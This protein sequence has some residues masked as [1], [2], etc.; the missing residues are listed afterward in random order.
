MAKVYG[1][2]KRGKVKIK[3]KKQLHF[4]FG[5]KLPFTLYHKTKKGKIQKKRINT[6]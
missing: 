6:R 2:I 4:L 1:T 5:R 3:S